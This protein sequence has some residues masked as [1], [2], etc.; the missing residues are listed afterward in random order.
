M[1]TTACT[2]TPTTTTTTATKDALLIL[3]VNGDSVNVTED[4]LSRLVF[5]LT[6][7][8]LS[9][10]PPTTPLLLIIAVILLYARNWMLISFA[11]QRTIATCMGM[12]AAA[13]ADK[14]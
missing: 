9:T 11:T 14:T 5:V 12:G 2:T 4:F 8:T 13:S 1:G 6:V 3:T 10:P 7:T